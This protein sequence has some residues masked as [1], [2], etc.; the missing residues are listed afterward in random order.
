MQMPR[1]GRSRNRSQITVAGRVW[2]KAEWEE[3]RLERLGQVRH[4]EEGDFIL[5]TVETYGRFKAGVVVFAV[6]R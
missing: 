2:G 3:M 6:C 5:S 4:G 1:G